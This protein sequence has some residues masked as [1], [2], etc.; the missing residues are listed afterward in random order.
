MKIQPYIIPAMKT[1][2]TPNF[3][4]VGRLSPAT[5]EIGKTRMYISLKTLKYAKAKVAS[6]TGDFFLFKYLAKFS[7]NDDPGLGVE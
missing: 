3:R 2:L 4:R 7:E 1:R 5:A 6:T